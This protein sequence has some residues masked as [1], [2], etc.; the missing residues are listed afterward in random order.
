MAC[1]HPLR[2]FQSASGAVV[3]TELQRDNIVR[4]LDLPCG[5][6]IGC[7]LDR[8][9]HWATR[10]VHEASQHHRNAF[11]TLTYNNDNLPPY[12]SLRYRDY[13]L[14]I[15]RLRKRY[16][17]VRYYMGGEYGE[18]RG[19]PHYH[20]CLFGF[21]FDDKQRYKRT[22][23]GFQLYTSAI[24]E[25]LWGKGFCT[26]GEVNF[27]TAAYVARYIVQKQ[28][29]KNN[30][31]ALEKYGEKI[32]VETGEITK[33]IP[34]FNHMSLKPGIGR[35]WVDKYVTD[36]INDGQV[37]INGRKNKAP[38]YYDKL[39]KKLYPDKYEIIQQQRYEKGQPEENYPHRL[40]AKKQVKI[41]QTHKLLRTLE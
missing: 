19:R 24:L 5:Q 26:I 23:G 27:E 38:R 20:A 41:A 21:D 7:R 25:Q 16:G 9:R 15:K 40:E 8:S 17:T 10:C 35:T 11:V 28:T 34:E 32:D 2:A 31:K 36:I 14:F 3:F 22:P 30:P 13:Q 39:I 33:K 29:G 4:T 12:A 6:C 18:L 37:V 1:Y